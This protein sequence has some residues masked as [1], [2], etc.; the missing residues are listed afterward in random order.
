V[1]EGRGLVAF[2][3][4]K[5]LGGPQ[6]GL[7]V[8]PAA[9]VRPL[10]QHPLARALRIDKLSLAALEATLR[11]YDAPTPAEESVP[12]LRMLAQ[13]PSAIAQ[14]AA[15]LARRL[16]REVPGIACSVRAGESLAGGGALPEARLPTTLVLLGLPGLGANELAARLRAAQPPVIVRIVDDQVALDLRTVASGEVAEIVRTLAEIAGELED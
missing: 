16:R 7:V 6:A 15:R 14:R 1:R 4:D 11:L 8:G 10:R 2:S 9:L 13:A 5:L 3:G 12:T